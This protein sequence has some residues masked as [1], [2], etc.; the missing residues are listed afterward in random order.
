MQHVWADTGQVP[1]IIVTVVLAGVLGGVLTHIF[2]RYFDNTERPLGF[3]KLPVIT[4]WRIGAG[5]IAA[6]VA[7]GLTFLGVRPGLLLADICIAGGL[8]ASAVVDYGFH[9][10][11][12]K[13]LAV[14][15]IGGWVGIIIDAIMT[16][17]YL[18]LLWALVGMLAVAVVF[19]LIVKTGLGAADRNA[20]VAVAAVIG[21]YSGAMIIAWALA[22]YIVAGI[23][24]MFILPF[25]GANKHT[26]KM[27]HVPPIAYALVLFPL[28]IAVGFG[29][30]W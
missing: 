6:L 7:W 21:Y 2:P 27:A 15:F 13:V 25:A 5:V 20:M 14:P 1:L 19:H 22:T 30:W 17:G 18:N 3:D 16:G 9:R 11:P 24:G 8:A 23:I 26:A 12:W 28:Y 10:V 4:S 29:T